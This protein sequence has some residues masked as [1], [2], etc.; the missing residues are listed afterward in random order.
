MHTNCL[1]CASLSQVEQ[2]NPESAM[3]YHAP[4]M[5]TEVLEY[6]R[7]REGAVC[8]DGTLG[9]GGHSELLLRAGAVVIG[10]DQDQ[11]AIST[12]QERLS[13]FGD[14]FIAERANFS[15]AGEVLDR[16]GIDKLH[17]VVLDLGVSSHQLNTA[18]RGFSFQKDGPLDMRM[19]QSVPITA[20]ELVNQA[21]LEELVR[22]FRDY[23][24]EPKAA[25]VASRLVQLR[26]SRPFR[27]TFDLVAAVE[28]AIRRTGP[29]NPATRVFQALRIAVNSELRVLKEGLQV[30]SER[31]APGARMV[32]LTFHSL[33]DR[34]VKHFLREHSTEWIDRPEWPEPRPNPLCSFRLITPAPVTPSPAETDNNPR[35][36][37][38]KLRVAEKF[39]PEENL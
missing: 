28:S 34:I 38:A 10:L 13:D 31:L 1:D 4:V 33:E 3:V 26:V 17:G 18:E 29:R 39:N 8:L 23:G 20:A 12:A 36:R 2:G 37:S 27:T 15:M 14:R 7:P 30:L 9:G 24:E 32:V 19:D 11:N 25:R 16:L 35:A 22:I 21:P 6:L 5:P